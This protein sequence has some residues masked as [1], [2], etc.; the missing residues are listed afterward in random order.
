MCSHGTG[1]YVEAA[2]GVVPAEIAVVVVALSLEGMAGRV[3]Q[4]APKA[5]KVRRLARAGHALCTLVQDEDGD[6]GPQRRSEDFPKGA[7]KG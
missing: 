1:T 7:G 6:S 4:A 2:H 5:P 3:G